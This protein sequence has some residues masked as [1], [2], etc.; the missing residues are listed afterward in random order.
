MPPR[1]IWAQSRGGEASGA[2]SGEIWALQAVPAAFPRSSLKQ[3]EGHLLPLGTGVCASQSRAGVG[4]GPPQP[5]ECD[6]TQ[7]RTDFYYYFF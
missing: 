2:I 4:F 5:C 3:P 1:S 7:E 6:S